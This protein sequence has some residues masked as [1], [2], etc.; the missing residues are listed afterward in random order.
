[1]IRVLANCYD[2]VEIAGSVACELGVQGRPDPNGTATATSAMAG[3]FSLTKNHTIVAAKVTPT[4]LAQFD[5]FADPT[6]EDEK[7]KDMAAISAALQSAKAPA[8]V[9]RASA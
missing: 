2:R 3:G 4:L 5:F 6:Y 9:R 7:L 1:M 8:F